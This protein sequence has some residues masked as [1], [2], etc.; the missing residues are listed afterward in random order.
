VLIVR[1]TPPIDVPLPPSLQEPLDSV[2][3]EYG[4]SHLETNEKEAIQK[5]FVVKNLA[6]DNCES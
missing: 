6:I 3:M 2:S 5:P 1:Y 4:C